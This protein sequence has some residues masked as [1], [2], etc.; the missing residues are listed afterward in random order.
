MS[1]V[2]V[3]EFDLLNLLI[4][5]FILNPILVEHRLSFSMHLLGR[6]L[7]SYVITI[8]S[9]LLLRFV[10]I[11]SLVH[12][13]NIWNLCVRFI[14]RWVYQILL[15][16][17]DV[18]QNHLIGLVR[19]HVLKIILVLL[20]LLRIIWIWT[21][22]YLLSFLVKIRQLLLQLFVVLAW[23]LSIRIGA[24]LTV[25]LIRWLGLSPVLVEIVFCVFASQLLS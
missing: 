10:G 6:I 15:N 20:C 3:T 9:W 24:I 25:H 16:I 2:T 19:H 22:W 18:L 7:L 13:R 14:V 11:S 17:L 12:V 5:V 8:G 4:L 1:E 23:S 21:I